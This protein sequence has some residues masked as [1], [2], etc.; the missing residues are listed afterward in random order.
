MVYGG[1]RPT[2][3]DVLTETWDGTSWT[4]VA[5]LATARG[6]PGGAGTTSSSALAISGTAVP[7]TTAVEEWSDPGPATTVTFTAS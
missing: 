4:E 5:D 1:N 6:G 2:N 7:V 3:P